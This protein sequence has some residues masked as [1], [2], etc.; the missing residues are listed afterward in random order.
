MKY[1]APTML[2]SDEAHISATR[3]YKT[4]TDSI[5]NDPFLS[6]V[7][8]LLEPPIL[9]LSIALGRTTDS[10]MVKLVESKDDVRDARF[11][12]FRDYC[13]ALAS[14]DDPA[15]ASAAKLLV[16]ILKE[17]GWTLYQEGDATESSLLHTLFEK[18]G[19][20]PESTYVTAIDATS[21]LAS[22][23]AAQ[24]DFETTITTK[25]DAKTKQEYPKIRKCRHLIARYL[26]G[27]LDYIDLMAEIEGG[28]YKTAVGK[29]DEI[30]TE[31]ETIARSRQTRKETEKTK[32]A[33]NT[34][35]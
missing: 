3:L 6:K 7:G 21:R 25:V 30:I 34:A 17:L 26:G 5:P 18:L 33:G 8:K 4:A 9:D 32:A 14:D 1:Y 13:K 19:K 20:A 22:L 15:V 28:V 31:F 2:S 27:M 10:T 23:K 35:S 11:I 12:G 16:H 24:L 29:I